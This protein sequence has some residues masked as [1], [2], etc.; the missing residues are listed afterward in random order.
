MTSDF[1]EGWVRARS[2]LDEHARPRHVVDEVVITRRRGVRF[3]VGRRLVAIGTQ[4][5][6]VEDTGRSLRP[7]A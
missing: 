3:R 7:A 4:L 1:Y 2:V 6:G 5:M